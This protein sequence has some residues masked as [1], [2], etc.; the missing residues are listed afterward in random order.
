[1]SITKNLSQV[2]PLLGDDNEIAVMLDVH[3][4]TVWRWRNGKTI[5]PDDTIIRIA[6][7]LGIDPGTLRY[8]DATGS[9]DQIL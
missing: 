8:G 9:I 6:N 5:P 7:H 3:P 2:L 1:M 4:T